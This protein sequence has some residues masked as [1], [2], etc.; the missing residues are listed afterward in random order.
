[1]SKRFLGKKLVTPFSAFLLASGLFSGCTTPP[2][3]NSA[4]ID[5][6]RGNDST[7]TE[8]KA[9]PAAVNSDAGQNREVLWDFRKIDDAA[10]PTFPKAETD[11]VLKYLLGDARD[12]ELEITS[13]VAGAFTKRGAKETLYFVTGCKN[14][15]GA[16]VSNAACGHV[17]WN[18][19]GWIAVFDGTTPVMKTEEALGG[20]IE[21]VTDV[22]G[23]G[24]NEILSIGGYTGMGIV[25]ESAALGQLSGGRFEELKTFRGSADN[26]GEETSAGKKAI[27][28][29]IRYAPPASGKMPDFYEEY[30]LTEC[31]GDTIA[32]NAKWAKIEKKEFDDFFD[33][34]S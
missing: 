18:T 7:M 19:A 33:A 12:P 31:A 11:A 29:V 15:A 17:G 20:A 4:A 2:S 28:A 26:C 10:P 23:D 32:D 5:N 14:E 13:R 30:F 21:K 6:T 9:E 1:M 22:N 25:T 34:V 16:F 24:V 8:K 27:A 3:K